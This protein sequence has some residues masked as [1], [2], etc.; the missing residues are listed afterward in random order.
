MKQS[1][2]IDFRSRTT[3][4]LKMSEGKISHFDLFQTKHDTLQIV[5]DSLRHLGDVPTLATGYGRHLL[6]QNL[7]ISHVTEIKACARGTH[8]LFPSCRTILDVGGQDCKVIALDERGHV[9]KFEMND[10]CAA[11]T[12]RFL[13]V[14]AQTFDSDISGFVGMALAAETSIAINS[15]CTVFAESEVISLITS[16]QP[17][18]DIALGLHLA[19][20]DRLA[21]M[22]KKIDIQDDILF[23]GGGAKNKCLHR[24]L[25]KNLHK[26]FHVPEE[27]QITA[28]LGAA[29][30]A[31]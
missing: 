10:R 12:G 15:I 14:M 22:L 5:Q 21:A 17:R 31:S 27:P 26:S 7:N 24:Q 1:I 3:K 4:I 25:E 11:G 8:H 19:I 23:V 29:L 20:T 28:A 9:T 16:G 2:G 30:L 13:E 6:N 18:E